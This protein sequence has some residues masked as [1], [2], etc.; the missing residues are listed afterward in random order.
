MANLNRRVADFDLAG[1]PVAQVDVSGL[2]LEDWR[3]FLGV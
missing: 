3:D 1:P 2:E